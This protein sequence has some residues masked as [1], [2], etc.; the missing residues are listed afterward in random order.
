MKRKTACS[1]TG[2]PVPPLGSTTL[3]TVY[4]YLFLSLSPSACLPQGFLAFAGSTWQ[5]VCC[6]VW[7]GIWSWVPSN[8]RWW[9]LLRFVR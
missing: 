2:R 7:L 8:L 1:A 5:T 4:V 3:A 9:A 6:V